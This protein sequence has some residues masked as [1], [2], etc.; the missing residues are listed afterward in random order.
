MLL[1]IALVLS[2]AVLAGSLAGERERG[3]L[4]LLLTTSVSAR[5]VVSG[6][7]AGKLSQVGMILLGGVPGLVGI[8]ALAG[9]PPGRIGAL[10][11]LPAG[12]GLGAGGLAALASTVAR[13]GRD[14]LLAVYFFELLL[15]LS[16]LVG[17]Y[18]LAPTAGPW[19]AAWN[20]YFSLGP[21][22]A[23]DEISLALA[24]TGLWAILGLIGTVLSAWRLRPSC[25][26]ASD[27]ERIAS[28]RK[29]R[30]FVPPIYD[31]QP[32]VWKELFIERVGTLGRFGRW[33]GWLLVILLMGGSLALSAVIALDPS[34]RYSASWG[35]WARDQLEFWIGNTGTLL[36]CLIQFAIGLRAAVSISSE[37]ER[38]TWD[39]LMTSPLDGREIVRGK[40]RGSLFA[41][42]AV[43]AAALLAWGIAAVVEAVHV[44]DAASWAAEVVFVGAFMAAVGV[45]ASLASATATRA[46]ALTIG[47]WL[48]AWVS[49]RVL[50]FLV[51][52]TVTLVGNA[53]RMAAGELG[54]LPPQT[55]FWAPV[56]WAVAWP[57]SKGWVYLLATLLIVADSRLRFDWLAGR[58]TEG[59]AAVAFELLLHGRPEAPVLI[60]ERDDLF[61]DPLVDWP[62]PAP[63]PTEV[64]PVT[65]E[66]SS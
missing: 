10:L 58:M 22:V 12:V 65:V 18:G 61:E 39:A 48:G 4:A 30:G 62:A 57:V 43:I 34:P 64:G 44:K 17:A 66:G 50:A 9:F 35:D 1:T 13:R 56:A 54:L 11:L 42:K 26:R 63:D 45:R 55:A 47:V 8:A 60:D 49:V 32:M 28:N 25:L 5:E 51:L 16:P 23:H 15:M 6:R 37:R 24:A 31:T 21:L 20:P 2:P 3:A 14:A 52:A 7:L 29:R 36:A 38:G 46:M 59:K 27:G 19:I 40:L 41:L 53:I 33:A